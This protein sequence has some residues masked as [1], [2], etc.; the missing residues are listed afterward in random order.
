MMALSDKKENTTYCDYALL[1]YNNRDYVETISQLKESLKLSDDRSPILAYGGLE[2]SLL[3]IFFQ[4]EFYMQNEI[5][6]SS[7]LF[8]YYYLIKCTLA[9]QD[10]AG[11][12]LYFELLEEYAENAVSDKAFA[13]RVLSYAALCINESVS[14]STITYEKKE[15]AKR[16][17]V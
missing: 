8:N 13:R 3:D 5:I 6:L 17:V 9:L 15:K 7:T 2:K 14:L 10:K 4:K 1:L 12:N 16:T 11:C